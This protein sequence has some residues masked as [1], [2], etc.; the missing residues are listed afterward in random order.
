VGDSNPIPASK[1]EYEFARLPNPFFVGWLGID[2]NGYSSVNA[3][4]RLRP[5]Q[6]TQFWSRSRT[7]KIWTVG[8]LPSILRIKI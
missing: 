2:D 5:L 4:L 7:T 8:I 1:K 3:I 6:N